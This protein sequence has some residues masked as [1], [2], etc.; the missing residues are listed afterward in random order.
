MYFFGSYFII[1][2]VATPVFLTVL[3]AWWVIKKAWVPKTS[4]EQNLNIP[5]T[6]PNRRFTVFEVTSLLIGILGLTLPCLLLSWYIFASRDSVTRIIPSR[7]LDATL[8]FYYIIIFISLCIGA[9]AVILGMRALRLNDR[10]NIPRSFKNL[11]SAGI[12]LGFLTIPCV[13]LPILALSILERACVH[14][15]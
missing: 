9:I 12:I 10:K 2:L 13:F 8:R 7:N 14:G 15:C 6:P 3:A 11:A 5:A 4:P 1:C